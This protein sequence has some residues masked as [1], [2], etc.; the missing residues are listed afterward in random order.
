P[1]PR[2]PVPPSPIGRA[3]RRRIICCGLATT[4]TTHE[5]KE[6]GKAARPLEG[7]CGAHG[8]GG[9][10]GGGRRDGNGR[11]WGGRREARSRR[12]RAA[13]ARLRGP[14]PEDGAPGARPRRG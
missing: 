12:E 3:P 14:A 5:R 4:G 6:L 2:P 13:P 1:S 9:G 11:E 10:G 8:G 7:L